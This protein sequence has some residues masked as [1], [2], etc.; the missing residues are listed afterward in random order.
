MMLNELKLEPTSPMRVFCDNKAAI[1]IAHNPVQHDRTKHVEVDR[2]FIKEKIESR[3]ITTPY[4]TTNQQLADILTKW[5][6]VAVFED[7]VSKL[8]MSDIYSPAWGGVLEYWLIILIYGD[9]SS[10]YNID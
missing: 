7:L 10:C 8:G 4:V 6:T 1:S 2:H 9:N 3:Q 5:V